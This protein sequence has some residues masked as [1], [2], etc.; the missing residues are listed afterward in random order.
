MCVCSLCQRQCTTNDDDENAFET[1]CNHR[2]S[3]TRCVSGI[4][5]HALIQQDHPARPYYCYLMQMYKIPPKGK[6]NRLVSRDY[7]LSIV[8]VIAFSHRRWV[9]FFLCHYQFTLFLLALFGWSRPSWPF[10]AGGIF[11]TVTAPCPSCGAQFSEVIEKSGDTGSDHL[12]ELWRGAQRGKHDRWL[13]GTGPRCRGD[14]ADAKLYSWIDVC[15]LVEV[16]VMVTGTETW[17]SRGGQW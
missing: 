14:S 3:S 7:H 6:A 1:G 2:R 16:A 8:G 9:A 5:R 13:A 17:R 11:N 12:F 4:H 10:K 15:C